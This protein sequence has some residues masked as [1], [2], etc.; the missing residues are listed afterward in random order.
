MNATVNLRNAHL[1]PSPL[2]RLLRH[3]ATL[4]VLVVEEFFYPGEIP[5]Y[6]IEMYFRLTIIT[7]SSSMKK[8][9]VIN[10]LFEG[11]YEPADPHTNGH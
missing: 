5:F 10:W 6:L 8:K 3:F 1:P 4:F 7:Q 9:N 2:R 11:Q